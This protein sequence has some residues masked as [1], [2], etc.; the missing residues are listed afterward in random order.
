MRWPGSR[1]ARNSRALD[2]DVILKI[3][4]LFL[5]VMAVMAMFGRWR[6]PGAGRLKNVKCPRCGRYRIGKG[7]CPCGQ[8]GRS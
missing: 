1:N 6:F 2:S 8:E 7:S 3:V 4:L 5:V